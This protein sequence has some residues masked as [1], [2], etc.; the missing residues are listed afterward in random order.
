VKFSSHVFSRLANK[1][2]VLSK[3]TFSSKR[4]KTLM[5]Y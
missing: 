3:T 1:A 5:K 4:E 2:N